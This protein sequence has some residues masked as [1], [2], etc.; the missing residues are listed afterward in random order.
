MAGRFSVEAVFKAK[1]RMTAPVSRMQNRVGKF[2]RTAERG[3]KRLNNNVDKFT[4][5]VKAGAQAV[6]VAAGISAA[7]FA[8]VAAAGMDFEQTMVNAAVKFPGEIRKGTESFK[9]LQSAARETGAST[10]FSAQQAA[11]AIDFLAMAGFNA[12]SSI[13]ALPGVVDLATASNTDLATATDIA[14]DSLGAFNLMTEDATQLQKNL[15]RVSDVMAATTTSA[16][17]T[18]RTM[19]E[20][21]KEA[22]P[23]YTSA[24]QSMET[25]AALTGTLANAGIK[26]SKAGT[27]LKGVITRL[28]A[29]TGEAA[30]VIERIG[31]QTHNAD[32][33]F[34]DIT[35]IIGD[36]T[37][38]TGD[39]TDK[40][41]AAAVR[42]IIGTEAMAG[43]EVMTKAG[44][45]QLRAYRKEL[46][47]ATG[48]SSEMA[49]VMRDTT[50]GS[51]NA[52]KSAIEGVKISLFTMNQGPL[53]ETIDKT[54]DWVRANEDLIAQNIGGFVKS[55]FD[56]LDSILAWIKNIGTAMAVLF[57]LNTVL[58]T[59]TAIMTAVNLVMAA[60]PVTLIVLGIMALTAAVVAA[61]YYWETWTSAVS[62]FFDG[63][64]M[65]AKVAGVALLAVMSPILA[66][67]AAAALIH[68]HWEPIKTFFIGLWD[69]IESRFESGVAKI[70]ELIESVAKVY[71]GVADKV[72]S[73]ASAPGKVFD[74]AVGGVKNFFGMGD[75]E[76]GQSGAS[77]APDAQMVSPQER[78]SRSIEE[79]RESGTLTIEDKTERAEV[80]SGTLPRG[81]AMQRSGAF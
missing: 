25:L 2:T 64:P 74:S 49:D 67:V 20:T 18:M 38:I 45:E 16:N 31:L 46:E 39:M 35:K 40:Q 17:V 81:V 54:T 10:E 27:A 9:E 58:K 56:N 61:I 57:V 71:R 72:E 55:V 24:G 70:R 43:F 50:K 42:T 8:N 78:V 59:F 36:F 65:W 22:G 32:G 15:A 26:G 23:V 77:A 79:R 19:F 80:T 6:T 68:K 11:S 1:D 12:E 41:R 66:L 28:Q 29:P 48:A 13:A 5:G 33:S 21:V 62:G 60:N 51:Y 73:V 52:L 75:D 53:K 3:F 47:G 76:S 14:S 34:R 69:G 7:A 4:R 44:G 63:I 37:K 30:K